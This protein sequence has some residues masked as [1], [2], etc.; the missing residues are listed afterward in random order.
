MKKPIPFDDYDLED[1]LSKFD[2]KT[3]EHFEIY[4]KLKYKLNEV[5]DKNNRQLSKSLKKKI[6]ES[7]KE[8][9]GVEELYNIELFNLLRLFIYDGGIYKFEGIDVLG[10]IEARDANGDTFYLSKGCLFDPVR[11]A[12]KKE[13]R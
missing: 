5:V 8:A 9:L 4:F 6:S 3:Q 13:L 11:D 7:L 10:I 2:E 1:Y 12:K